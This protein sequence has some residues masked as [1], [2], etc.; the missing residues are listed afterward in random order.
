MTDTER[1]PSPG[2]EYW[3]EPLEASKLRRRAD[4]AWGS[5]AQINKAA[6]ELSEL[7]ACLNRHQNGQQDPDELLEELVDARIMLWQLEAMFGADQIEATTRAALD[8]LAD[9]LDKHGRINAGGQQ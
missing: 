3:N 8:D 5:D 2:H 7:A 1:G 9:R 4:T 6:E